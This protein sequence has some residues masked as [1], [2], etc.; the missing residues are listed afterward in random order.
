MKKQ[1]K[2][3]VPVTR[4]IYNDVKSGVNDWGDSQRVIATIHGVSQCTVSKIVNSKNFKQYK[5]AGKSKPVAKKSTKGIMKSIDTFTGHNSKIVAEIK[6]LL[7]KI[8]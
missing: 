2:A 3:R 6:Q 7:K 8:I 4:E 5:N 1:R